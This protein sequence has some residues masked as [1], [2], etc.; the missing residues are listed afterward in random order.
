MT[1]YLEAARTWQKTKLDLIFA[2]KRSKLGLFQ[3]GNTE[4]KMQGVCAVYAMSIT[5][6]SW[7]GIRQHI[8]LM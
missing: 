6:D 4:V 5:E 1:Q 8:K 2:A 3:L 7:V